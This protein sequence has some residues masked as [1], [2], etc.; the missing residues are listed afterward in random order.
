MKKLINFT[1]EQKAALTAVIVEGVKKD[2]SEDAFSELYHNGCDEFMDAN[3]AVEHNALFKEAWNEAFKKHK[4]KLVFDKTL[5]SRIEWDVTEIV[6]GIAE[7]DNGYELAEYFTRGSI[8]TALGLMNKQVKTS[9]LLVKALEE[10]KGG[11]EK[12]LSELKEEIKRLGY[13]VKTTKRT[14]T[15]KK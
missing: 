15:K 14:A 9:P 13:D 3:D 2:I 6:R 11:Q 4:D 10:A 8:K 1:E 7:N 12:R 5:L